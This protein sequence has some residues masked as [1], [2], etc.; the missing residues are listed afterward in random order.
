M[1]IKYVTPKSNSIGEFMQKFNAAWKKIDSRIQVIHRSNPHDPQLVN[2]LKRQQRINME[3][4]WLF[5]GGA[6]ANAQ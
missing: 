6:N 2:L 5:K 4:L 1:Q 3:R